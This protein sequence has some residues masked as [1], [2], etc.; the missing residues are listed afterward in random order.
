MFVDTHCHLEKK[1][2]LSIDKVINK[3]IEDGVNIFIVSGYDKEGNANAIELAKRHSN[4]Y[5]TIGYGPNAA[6]DITNGDLKL[7]GEQAL[8]K[9]VVG[10]GEIGLDYYRRKDNKDKQKEI[11]IE[12]IKIANNLNKPIV[13]H[14]RDAD[15]DIYN[16]LSD[17]AG[18]KKGVIHCF[19]S[20]YSMG[21]KF[22]KLG[23]FLG[24]GGIVTFN[25]TRLSEVINK[26]PL[27]YIVLETDSPYLAPEPQRGKQN[28]PRFIKNIAEKV[29]DIKGVN[30]SVVGNITTSNSLGLFDLSE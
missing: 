25:N 6:D 1:Y 22:V 21:E 2:Y 23:F 3:A 10:I 8:E 5:A 12:Q 17:L 19:N 13:I 14:N 27:E 30:V 11:F 16:I 24:I 28:E 7:L 4:V 9:K 29:A 20:S 18:D 26:L 15:D